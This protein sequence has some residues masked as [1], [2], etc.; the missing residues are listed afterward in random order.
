VIQSMVAI[1][2]EAGRGEVTV[3]GT[4]FFKKEAWFAASLAGLEVR[5]YAPTDFER[6][7]L[8][9][10]LGARR[11]AASSEVEPQAQSAPE[12]KGSARSR[13]AEGALI[14]GKLVD[15]G[16]APYA[17]DPRQPMSYFVR[18]ETEQGDREIWGVDLER[19]F[20]TR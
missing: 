12:L 6:E 3:S 7:R 16:P 8:A 17:H 14:V 15:H 9:R 19:A 13:P 4:E 10:A 1:A 18:I 5:G 20:A 2:S 11:G